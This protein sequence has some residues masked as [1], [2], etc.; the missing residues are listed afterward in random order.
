MTTAASGSGK[1]YSHLPVIFSSHFVLIY[2]EAFFDFTA[3]ADLVS[4]VVVVA[5]FAGMLI[6]TT[7]RL[8]AVARLE[9]KH[10]LLLTVDTGLAS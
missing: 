2:F 8:D 3:F 4:C 9:L 6:A 1:L 10:V 7:P 5:D